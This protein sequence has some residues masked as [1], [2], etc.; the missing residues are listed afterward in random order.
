MISAA[1]GMK[2][3]MESLD[4][5]ANNVAN[6]GTAGFKADREFYSLYVS[7]EA[8]Q[9]AADGTTPDPSTIPVIERQWTDL[10]QGSLLST[11]NALDLAISGKG[12]FVVDSANGPIYTRNGSFRLSSAGQLL[13]QDGQ[14][15]RVLRPDGKPAVF[16]PAAPVEINP[17]GEIQQNGQVIGRLALVD[18]DN[19]AKPVKLGNTYFK[20]DESSA[21]PAT[22]AEVHQGSLESANVPVGES[23]VR[24]V[25]VMRQFEML[26]RAIS[27]GSEMDRKSI[28][29][30]AKAGG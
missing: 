2:A 1:S 9:G 16:D 13:T 4:L 3:R 6:S 27:L 24:L 5:L 22:A 28:E 12:M 18:V 10:G 30:V 7:E 29:E 21:K 14:P 11:G 19:S 17:K 25:S 23:A 8:A 26:Q 15:V 20:F